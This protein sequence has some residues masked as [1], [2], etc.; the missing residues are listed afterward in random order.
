MYGLRRPVS[1]GLSGLRLWPGGEAHLDRCAGHRH[2][3]GCATGCD[4]RRVCPVGSEHR[5]GVEEETFRHSYS[6]ATLRRWYGLGM[7]RFV[8]RRLR[9]R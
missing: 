1:Y 7:W 5:Y 6:L 8:P 4:V 3:G 2:S 9:R